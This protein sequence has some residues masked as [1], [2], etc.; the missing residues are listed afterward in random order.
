M[1]NDAKGVLRRFGE[2]NSSEKNGKLFK[3]LCSVND[4]LERTGKAG[5]AAALEKLL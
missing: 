1:V 3:P 2:S 4:S 5:K